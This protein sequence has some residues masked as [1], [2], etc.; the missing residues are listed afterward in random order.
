MRIRH[1]L[2]AIVSTLV[3]S[4]LIILSLVAY[5]FTKNTMNEA[6][7]ELIETTADVQVS[8]V[9]SFL[10]D[11]LS[12]VQGFANLNALM[13]V[14]PDEAVSEL[15]R[16]YPSL[17]EDF[18]N[19]SFANLEGTRWNYKGE[20]GSVG[21]REY[22]KQTIDEKKGVISDVLISNTT[23]EPAVIVTAPILDGDNV[24]GIA[25]ATLELDRL[26]TVISESEI[27]ENGFGFMLDQEGMVLAHGREAN[28]LAQ[29]ITDEEF[30]QKHSLNYIWE[31]KKIEDDSN[32]GQ[33][34]HKVEKE[35]YLTTITPVNVEGN[36]PWFLGVSVEKAEIEQNIRQLGLIF[37][38]LSIVSIIITSLI[39]WFFS[40][41]FV[42]PIEQISQ[43]AN[44]VANGDLTEN[45]LEIDTTD[46]IGELYKN[47]TL[48][49]N[50]LR[51]FVKTI[52]QNANELANSAEN[53]TINMNQSA[54]T[55]LEVSNAVEEIAEGTS[56]QANDMSMASENL[57]E[58]GDLIGREQRHIQDLYQ[59]ASHTDS[60]RTE[61]F[62][63]IDDLKAKTAE[64]IQ[65]I[66]VI[67]EVIFDTDKSAREIEE[68]SK[69]IGN[70]A[71]QTNLLALNASIEAAR[72]G[73]SGRGFTVVA[74]EI[75]NL[76]EDSNKFTS[77]IAEVINNLTEK[78]ELA[79]STI[80]EV[81]DLANY[82]NE[83]VQ[84]TSNKFEGIAAEIEKIQNLIA[85]VTNLGKEMEENKNET[86]V[87]IENL[88]AISEETA[89]GTEEV[90]AS[91]EEQ[92][93]AIFVIEENTKILEDLSV[94]MK[95]AAAQFK[96]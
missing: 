58:L 41:S 45:E 31:N 81:E 27:G 78:T 9:E 24:K 21:D 34:A 80:K 13:S 89:A 36:S 35:D 47:I 28:L 75:R 25:Y 42:K 60:L 53:L 88:S 74:S 82:Q 86:I 72:A 23:N 55:S 76:A 18:A 77:I 92:S 69:M 44:R 30:D 87:K 62:E 32:Y 49:T 14:D 48:M 50:N 10:T 66:S 3:I 5:N 70:I 63:Q 84:T 90:S 20:E 38:A 29:T 40:K 4:S 96:Y 17:K 1:K 19:I 52:N 37:I 7:T 59:S 61:G 43:L 2:S 51:S 91:V 79:V 67:N 39:T 33:V 57:N 6:N 54:A 85:I 73:E 65:A 8:E 68:A 83:S 26:Q 11:S 95:K 56:E 46:E 93:N 64:N 16:V 71:E 15:N 12:K 94:E 22:F